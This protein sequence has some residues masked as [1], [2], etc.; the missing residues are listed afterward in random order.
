MAIG[1]YDVQ[2]WGKAYGTDDDVLG[3]FGL[4]MVE[5]GKAALDTQNKYGFS[6]NSG[7]DTIENR[8][9]GISKRSLDS[10]QVLFYPGLRP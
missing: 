1:E 7:S 8:G 4:S 6:M 10:R 9:K 2:D 3:K 5:V